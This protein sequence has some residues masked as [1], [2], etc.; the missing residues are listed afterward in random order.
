MIAWIIYALIMAWF[1]WQVFFKKQKDIEGFQPDVFL[2][3]V[4]WS[5]VAVVFNLIWGGIF[6]W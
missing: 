2:A 4:F 6:W 3:K 1:A 5:I